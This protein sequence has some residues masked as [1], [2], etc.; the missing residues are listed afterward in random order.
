M[1]WKSDDS[2]YFPENV[3]IFKE[4]NFTAGA[5]WFAKDTLLSVLFA[6]PKL[7]TTPI[8]PFP[9]FFISLLSFLERWASFK[10]FGGSINF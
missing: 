3:G 6:V 2:Q 8:A 5:I 10:L 1:S 7:D 4:A 9:N